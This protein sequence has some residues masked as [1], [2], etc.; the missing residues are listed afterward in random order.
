MLWYV[1]GFEAPARVQSP[2]SE[3][4]H[5]KF[6]IWCQEHAPLQLT[7]KLDAKIKSDL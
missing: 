7:H 1:L 5:I 2:A 6:L 3:V 4:D